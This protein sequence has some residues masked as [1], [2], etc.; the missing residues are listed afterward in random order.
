MVNVE[1]GPPEI[2][3]SENSRDAFLDEPCAGTATSPGSNAARTADTKDEMFLTQN[4][5]GGI[6]LLHHHHE[7]TFSQEIL[8]GT[9]EGPLYI[10]NRRAVT[11]SSRFDGRRPEDFNF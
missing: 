7:E 1:A 8:L 5:A 10:G 9:D 2:G 4:S 3:C 6:C 11:Y